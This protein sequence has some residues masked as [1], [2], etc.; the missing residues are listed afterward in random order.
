MHSQWLRFL[1][2]FLLI[3]AFFQ[4]SSS[5]QA[6]T[7]AEAVP[8]SLGIDVEEPEIALP[9]LDH[10]SPFRMVSRSRRRDTQDELVL[11]CREA[12]DTTSRRLLSTDQ[13][14]P[15]QMMHALL[16]LRQDFQI[17]HNGQ[18]ISGLDWVTQ[19]QIFDNE[20]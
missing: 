16:G 17:L 5:V 2:P 19:G 18:A 12:V 13:H 7:A 6:Q 1:S 10:T 8:H 20:Y 3:L 14:T 15:W 9:E 4:I 11:L